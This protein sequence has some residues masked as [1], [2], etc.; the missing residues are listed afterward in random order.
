MNALSLRKKITYALVVTVLVIGTL[1][2]VSWMM[3]SLLRKHPVSHAELRSVQNEIAGTPMEM[4]QDAWLKDTDTE[5]RV[6]H[7]YVGFVHSYNTIEQYKHA[8]A[9][10]AVVIGFTGGSVGR[11]FA[12]NM[13]ARKAFEARMKEIPAFADR[14]I[15]LINLA[16]DGYKQPQELQMMSYMIAIGTKFDVFILLDGVNDLPYVFTN[17]NILYSYE[18]PY[19]W[20]ER[21]T[22]LR[23][24]LAFHKYDNLIRLRANTAKFMR[25]SAMLRNSFSANALWAGLDGTLNWMVRKP[26]EKEDYTKNAPYEVFGTRTAEENTNEAEAALELAMWSRSSQMMQKLALSQNIEFF[27]FLQPNQHVAGS[28]PM[29]PEEAVVALT[30]PAFVKTLPEAYAKLFVEAKTLK[31]HVPFYD[32]TMIFKN[33]SEPLY[34]DACCHLNQTGSVLLGQAMADVV[35]KRLS[36]TPKR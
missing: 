27:H 8:G 16:A 35:I 22:A 2:T 23:E 34:V 15:M 33:V 29:R 25:N 19:F 5:R 21:M 28:K 4:T 18:Y 7:P 3:L 1:E 31:K 13:T 10:G 24:R 32:L 17:R 14:E 20:K 36:T 11:H 6:L 30:N 26:F 9:S 12:S